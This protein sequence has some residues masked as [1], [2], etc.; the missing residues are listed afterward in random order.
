MRNLLTLIV[1]ILPLIIASVV[2]YFFYFS[3]KEE[4]STTQ[5]TQTTTTI[6]STEKTTTT[7]QQTTTTT[8]EKTTTTTS[9]PVI[10]EKISYKEVAVYTDRFE[11]NEIIIKS[12]EKV[13]WTNK[14]N[15]EHEI[16]CATNGEP[17]FDV[18]INANESFDFSIYSNTECWD[19][20]VGEDKMRMKIIVQ[21]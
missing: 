8:I 20:T 19:P 15:K 16:V 11:P 21:S 2:F 17:L 6:Q 3:K 10:E 18:T 1:L 12:N 4:A 7:Q 5:I 14:D 13:K 9:L